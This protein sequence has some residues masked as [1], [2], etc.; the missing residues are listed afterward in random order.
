MYFLGGFL[1]LAPSSGCAVDT[2]ALARSRDAETA[3]PIPD[4]VAERGLERAVTFRGLVWR[5]GEVGEEL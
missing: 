3:S 1:G 2:F 5:R 4:A